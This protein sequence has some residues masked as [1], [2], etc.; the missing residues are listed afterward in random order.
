MKSSNKTLQ[1]RTI[2][3]KEIACN[4]F[5]GMVHITSTVLVK[6]LFLWQKEQ[7]KKI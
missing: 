6:I 7:N 2:F 3:I 1:V 4:T 5:L